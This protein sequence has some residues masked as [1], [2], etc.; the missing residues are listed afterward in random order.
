M[1]RFLPSPKYY[2]DSSSRVKAAQDR[3]RPNRVMAL[4]DLNRRLAK[5][6]W[7]KRIQKKFA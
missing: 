5:R 2:L 7:I 4:A 3:R 1:G 6:S